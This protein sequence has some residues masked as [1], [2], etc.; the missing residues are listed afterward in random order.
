MGDGILIS[1]SKISLC[2]FLLTIILSK[3]RYFTW[4]LA[5]PTGQYFISNVKGS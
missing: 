1:L 2:V 5:S 4:H 3:E